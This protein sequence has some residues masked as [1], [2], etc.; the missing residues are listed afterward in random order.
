LKKF[1]A[2]ALAAALAVFVASVASG[3]SSY[4]IP[5]FSSF[6]AKVTP[7]KAGTKK[8]PKGVKL[9]VAATIPKEARVTVD[10]L[11]FLL[12]RH[13][14]VSGTGFKTCPF[15]Q[16]NNDGV[17]SCPK[18]SKVGTGIA[19]AAFG[20]NL[21]PIVFDVT[22]YVGSK[23]ELAVYLVARGLPI[24]K[25]IRGIVSKAGTPYNQKLTIII[26]PE[27]QKQLGAYVYLTGLDTT[28]GGSAKKGKK[29]YN[30]ITTRG[31]PKTKKHLFEVR[32]HAV[33]NPNPP[34]TA[35]FSKTGTATCSGKP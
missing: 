26:P 6:T 32:A 20:P 24:Q 4:P 1:L 27:L 22:L 16:I 13:S 19:N 2:L 9:R 29:T 25:A 18:G 8:K 28:I 7:A 17:S 11:T 34:Q 21:T 3:Q 33:P 35:D 5:Q 12:P 14:T 10:T 23:S 15:T 30:L 31:C